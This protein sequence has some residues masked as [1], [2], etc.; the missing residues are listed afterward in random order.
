MSEIAMMRLSGWGWGMGGG[1]VESVNLA[2]LQQ[3]FIAEFVMVLIF[4]GNN[5]FL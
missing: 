5:A 3:S 4:A 2:C 1:G